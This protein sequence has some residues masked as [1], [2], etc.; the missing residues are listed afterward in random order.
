MR[1][2]EDYPQANF[3]TP[4]KIKHTFKET[5]DKEVEFELPHYRQGGN[6]FYKALNEDRCLM[7]NPESSCG[8]LIETAYINLMFCLD[9]NKEC[10]M[11]EFNEA[12]DKALKI[13]KTQAIQ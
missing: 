11:E 6:Y 3:D 1:E 12:F 8:A 7:V 13:L 9:G 2:N 10:T 4:I 5:I